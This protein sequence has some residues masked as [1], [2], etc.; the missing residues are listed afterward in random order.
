M[1]DYFTHFSCTLDVVTLDNAVRALELYR[2]FRDE[3]ETEG[4]TPGFALVAAPTAE[5]LALLWIYDGNASGDTDHVLAFVSKLGPMLGL[6]GLWGF[7]WAHTCSKPCLDAFGG[8]ALVI[9]L[10]SGETLGT[11]SSNEWLTRTLADPLTAG[12]A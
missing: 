1:A 9:D 7:E 10:A 5:Q 2:N 4:Q 11:I 6:T 8:G 12:E 3:L